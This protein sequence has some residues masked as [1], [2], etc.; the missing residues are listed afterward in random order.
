MSCS[1][2]AFHRKIDVA[3]SRLTDRPVEKASVPAPCHRS[4]GGGGGETKQSSTTLVMQVP[5]KL[6]HHVLF[7]NNRG[8]SLSLIS[9]ENS[10]RSEGD[11]PT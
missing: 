5:R 7:N 2:G 9:G 1:R 11:L 8:D 4:G 6:F 3:A 10:R